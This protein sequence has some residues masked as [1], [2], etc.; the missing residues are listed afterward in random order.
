M[1]VEE[2][3]CFDCA[4]SA[5][6]RVR[7]SSNHKVM[8]GSTDLCEIEAVSGA[9]RKPD[10]THDL[11]YRHSFEKTLLVPKVEA[12]IAR[13]KAIAWHEQLCV[14]YA[15]KQRF[16]K[17]R[18][19][20]VNLNEPCHPDVK[21]IASVASAI[22]EPG[23]RKWLVDTGC[24]FDLI[25]KGE[26]EDHEVAY[27]KR[28]MKAVRMS[29]PNGLVDANKSVSFSVPELGSPIDAYVLE[30]TPTDVSIGTRCVNLG[31]HFVWRPY[32]RPYIITPGGKKITLEV[33][34]NVPYL[35]V[36]KSTPCAAG[37]VAGG[38]ISENAEVI[39]VANNEISGDDEFELLE[40]NKRD[41]KTEAKSV[42]HMLTHL[43]KNPFCDVCRRAKLENAKSFR[44]RR[45]VGA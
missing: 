14:E 30:H 43:P 22:Y 20:D 18:S 45:C 29:T 17:G 23:V 13:M 36:V 31:Y 9:C 6:C 3:E 8:F 25:A 19:S 32:K 10:N 28:A 26:L 5:L 40:S 39:P 27:I 35:P 15:L 42:N 34:N 12:E 2:I 21:S 33:I 41:L 37:P 44:K 11:T 24:P 7:K 4:P 38:V 1:F 16:F